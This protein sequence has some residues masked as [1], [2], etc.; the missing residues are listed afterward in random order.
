MCEKIGIAQVEI[1]LEKGRVTLSEYQYVILFNISNA[2][3]AVNKLPVR[4]QSSPH[5]VF[6][7]LALA[8]KHAY[9]QAKASADRLIEF[10]LRCAS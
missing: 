5:N 9:S 1:N 10:L 3:C 2:L 6:L 4:S 8:G 7:C